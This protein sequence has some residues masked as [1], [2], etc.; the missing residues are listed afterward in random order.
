MDAVIII[1]V[2]TSIC[3]I[4]SLGVGIAS[5]LKYKQNL[6]YNP[7]LEY[8]SFLKNA[9]NTI[10][11]PALTPTLAPTLTPTLYQR[12]PAL[13]PTLYRRVPAP[14]LTLIP[15]S[16]PA[17]ALTPTLIT[18]TLIT[19]DL[20]PA[21]ALTPTST[22]APALTT[23]APTTQAPVV[24]NSKEKTLSG[25]EGEIAKF[26]CQVESGNLLFGDAEG[27]IYDYDL[28]NASSLL[29][30]LDQF[31]KDKKLYGDSQFKVTGEIKPE[32]SRKWTAKYQCFEP[33]Y[34]KTRPGDSEFKIGDTL[35]CTGGYDPNPWISSNG[36]S[37]YGLYRYMGN[38]KMRWYPNDEIAKSWDPKY[39][40]PKYSDCR[41]F[42]LGEDMKMKS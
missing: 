3:T 25:N 18:P 36:S 40:D 21:P 30:T 11:S 10:V 19:P 29:V 13:T 1:I 34:T 4:L 16:L 23:P 33:T 41:G 17:P 14:A 9:V 31:N 38:N 12:V 2:F 32:L 42:E 26:G 7:D 35:Q 28:W 20:T 5:Y 22:P 8:K 15:D 37:D 27:K 24:E 39:R 6:K